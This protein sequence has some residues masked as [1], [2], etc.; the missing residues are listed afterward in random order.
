MEQ[1]TTSVGVKGANFVYD[2]RTLLKLP[3]AKRHPVMKSG[4]FYAEL[5]SSRMYDLYTVSAVS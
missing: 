5:S 2:L 1:A 4:S 3:P